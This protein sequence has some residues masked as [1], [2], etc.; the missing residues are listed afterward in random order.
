MKKFKLIV[1][2]GTDGSGKQTQAKMLKERLER[3]GRK[4][5]S[6]S[7]PNYA[8]ASSAPVKMYLGGELC[9]T[10]EEFDAYQSSALFMVDRLCTMTQLVKSIEPETIIVLDRY[11]ESNVIHQGAKL[12]GAARDKFAKWLHKTEYETLKLPKPDLVLFLDLPFEISQ[13]LAASRAELKAGTKKD[14]HEA[15]AHHLKTAYDTGKYFAKKFKWTQITCEEN[16][17]IK[18]REKIADDVF[19]EVKK[20]VLTQK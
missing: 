1:I 20:L 3:E 4:V 16:G 9:D 8:S 11:V 15:D 6:L 17:V 7:F 5:V 18:S 10:P 12:S 14:I 2:E 13:K 19:C